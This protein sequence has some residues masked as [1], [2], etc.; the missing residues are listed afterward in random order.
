MLYFAYLITM[1]T[2]RIEQ[3]LY[4]HLLCTHLDRTRCLQSGKQ[5]QKT[6]NNNGY[7]NDEPSS[8]IVLEKGV[9]TLCYGSKD[10]KRSQD[11]AT[12]HAAA[13]KARGMI[14]DYS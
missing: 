2:N 12:Q 9:N 5:P 6:Q 10:N 14:V 3:Q 13:P 11:C 1:N 7:N 8:F 4:T